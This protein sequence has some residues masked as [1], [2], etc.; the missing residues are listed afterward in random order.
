MALELHI[1]LLEG[2]VKTQIRTSIGELVAVLYDEAATMTKD[3]RFQELLVP[4]ALLD[5]KTK[6]QNLRKFRK[7]K[8]TQFD[9]FVGKGGGS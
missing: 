1:S 8:I 2:I 5:L 9:S 6:A 7:R 3:Q 4:V